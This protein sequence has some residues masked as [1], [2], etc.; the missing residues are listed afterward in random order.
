MAIP[1]N[2]NCDDGT[3]GRRTLAE[4]V[5]AVIDGCGFIDLL[6]TGQT[7]TLAQMRA[8]VVDSLNVGLSKSPVPRAISDIVT[9]VQRALGFAANMGA[10]GVTEM[11]VTFINQAQQ[12]LWR[13]IE[14]SRV[15][16]PS[17]P[18]WSTGSGNTT[19][20]GELVTSMAILMAKAH[21]NK[22]DAPLYNAQIDAMLKTYAD[23]NTPVSDAQ[24]DAAIKRARFTVWNRDTAL[25]AM[26]SDGSSSTIHFVPIE[27]LAISNLKARLGHTDAA[28]FRKDYERYVAE[29][30]RRYPPDADG[31]VRRLVISAQEQLY[32][33]YDVLRTERF[34]SWEL[35]EGVT[36]Y[37]VRDNDEECDKRLDPRKLT[38][39]GVYR[40]DGSVRELVSGIPQ[41]VRSHGATAGWPTR[42]E[43]RSC[44]EVWP[45]PGDGEGRLVIKGRFGLEPF[46]D[47]THRAT[48]DDEAI[49]LFA[50]G[51]A[52]AHYRQP[53]A[54]QYRDDANKYIGNMTAGAHGT[55]FYHPDAVAYACRPDPVPKDGWLP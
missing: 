17:A 47:D 12:T 22:Q 49:Y 18:A 53:D 1:A 16:G 23:Q 33:K 14:Y 48:I 41:H 42:Y 34:Y 21:Y 54:G 20:D 55:K 39:V 11:V 40:E 8:S 52:K 26:E 25:P 9:D 44:I 32:R 45:P 7:K 5:A 35:T 27:L 24:I 3:F 19:V 46:S 6:L 4:L 37:D 30:E 29:A 38:W 2:C 10:P 15:G 28:Q 36:M 50:L 51:N 13:R 43:I 31:V